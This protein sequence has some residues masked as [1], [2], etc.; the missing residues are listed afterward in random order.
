MIDQHPVVLELRTRL[1]QLEVELLE[2]DRTIMSLE[3]DVEVLRETNRSL[4]REYGLAQ[5]PNDPT[6]G[7]V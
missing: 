3:D 2:K 1:A 4:V 5:K 7:S 6:S